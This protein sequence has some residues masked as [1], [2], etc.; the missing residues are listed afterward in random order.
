MSAT[1]ENLIITQL[2]EYMNDNKGAMGLTIDVLNNECPET[3][4]ALWIQPSGGDRKFQQY[5]GGSYKGSFFFELCYQM[6]NPELIDGRKANLDL[7]FLKVAT[8]LENANDKIVLSAATV[9]VEMTTQPAM[10][11]LSEDKQTVV[12]SASFRLEYNVKRP[13]TIKIKE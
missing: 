3:G 11:Y 12:H 1:V 9:K 10:S 13:I 6:T 4:E 2:V 5:V 7:P 8:Y